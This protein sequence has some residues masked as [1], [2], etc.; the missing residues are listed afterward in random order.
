MG[1]TLA[2]PPQHALLVDDGC[3]QP[4]HEE[5][6]S[7]GAKKIHAGTGWMMHEFTL[8]PGQ[9]PMLAFSRQCLPHAQL[10]REPSINAWARCVADAAMKHLP[11]G[12]PWRLYIMPKYGQGT[13]GQQRCKLIRDAVKEVL[14]KKRRAILRHLQ[15]T[16]QRFAHE[17]SLIQLVLLSPEEGL[18]SVAPAP[19]PYAQRQILW[20]FPLGEVPVE[21]DKA[22]PSRAFAKLAEA[23]LRLGQRIQA[24]SSCVDLGAAPGSW[25]YHALR[26]GAKVTAVDRSPLRDD[27]MQDRRLHFLQGDA[28]RYRPEKPV[29]WL[30][31]DIIAEPD[32]LTELLLDWLRGGHTRRFVFT[33]KFRGSE[34]YGALEE[35]KKQLPVLCQESYLTRL[36]AN[37]NEVTAYGSVS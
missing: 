3:E 13:A 23:E 26:R 29:D 9:R 2:L 34:G 4:L 30:I 37:K 17:D 33:I 5:L 18:L 10:L 19:L 28:F 1:D 22:A 14:Q 12:L 25:S 16:E 20:P 7:L 31:C 15:E 21:V 6:C 24:A 36:C 35:L 27:L 32:K 8:D 11:A